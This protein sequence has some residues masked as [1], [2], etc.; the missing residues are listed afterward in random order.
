MTLKL[1]V[2]MA[3]KDFESITTKLKSLTFVVPP[4]KVRVTA[5]AP[6]QSVFTVYVPVRVTPEK[7]TPLLLWV[8]V[9]LTK[10][11]LPSAESMP[12]KARGPGLSWPVPSSIRNPVPVT[13][14]VPSI[15]VGEHP[16]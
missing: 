15:S 12:T 10:F 16:A 3:S 11:P 13:S 5:P 1:S 8:S 4:G 7:I 9:P 6:V 2:I 14:Y